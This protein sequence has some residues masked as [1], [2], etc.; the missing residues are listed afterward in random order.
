MPGDY[1]ASGVK[2]RLKNSRELRVNEE[3]GE[4]AVLCMTSAVIPLDANHKM[5]PVKVI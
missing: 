4:G 1:T 5:V 3:T 2:C